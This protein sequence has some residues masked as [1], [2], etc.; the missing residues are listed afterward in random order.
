M[1]STDPS[2][3]EKE[4]RERIENEIRA[5]RA[6]DETPAEPAKPAVP[7]VETPEARK[8]RMEEEI[9]SKLDKEITSRL[10][11]PGSTRPPVEG[12]ATTDTPAAPAAATTD[13]A[14]PAE[15]S[16][17]TVA[18]GTKDTADA[19]GSKTGKEKGSK[20]KAGKAEKGKAGKDKATKGKGTKIGGKAKTGIKAGAKEGTETRTRT[21]KNLQVDSHIAAE[22]AKID[23]KLRKRQYLAYAVITITTVA[24]ISYLGFRQKNRAGSSNPGL[25]PEF[26]S[27]PELTHSPNPTQR[28]PRHVPAPAASIDSTIAGALSAAQNG[29]PAAAVVELKQWAATKPKDSKPCYDAIGQI[30]EEYETKGSASLAWMTL[31]DRVSASIESRDPAKI[32]EVMRDLQTFQADNPRE[33]FLAELPLLEAATTLYDRNGT[34][35]STSDSNATPDD[36]PAPWAAPGDSD[37]GGDAPPTGQ[38]PGKKPEPKKPPRSNDGEYIEFNFEM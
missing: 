26:Q 23:A 14:A 2:S 4:M 8:L 25:P 13:A 11:R 29:D 12:A 9:R 32:R 16:P 20:D 37:A 5:R 27:A 19:K 28:P 7:E 38:A 18:K 24:V 17:D 30:C 21:G 36:V 22:K 33:A 34:F 10:T 1:P 6:K 35:A 31:R 3:I 15:V